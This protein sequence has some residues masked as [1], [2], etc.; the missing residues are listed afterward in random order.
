MLLNLLGIQGLRV[1]QNGGILYV[2]SAQDKL[3]KTEALLFIFFCFYLPYCKIRF[4]ILRLYDF[5][6][7]YC[8]T[9]LCFSAEQQRHRFRITNLQLTIS[10]SNQQKRFVL[11]CELQIRNLIGLFEAD[12]LFLRFFTNELLLDA[13]QVD[14]VFCNGVCVPA[15]SLGIWFDS[16]KSLASLF[17]LFFVDSKC[18]A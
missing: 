13:L 16:S 6:L 11:F 2:F 4:F 17:F 5:N 9:F 14:Q 15:T 1:F 12:T 3:R 8:A 7:F 10:E 18:N